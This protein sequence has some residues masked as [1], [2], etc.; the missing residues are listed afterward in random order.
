MIAIAVIFWVLCI[1]GFGVL[2]VFVPTACTF[3]ALVLSVILP[4]VSA[5]LTFIGSRQLIASMTVPDSISKNTP[6]TLKVSVSN[7]SFFSLLRIKI[8][9][10]VENR[11]TGEVIQLMPSVSAG[12]H[13]SRTVELTFQSEHC[14]AMYVGIQDLK[15]TDAF[16]IFRFSAPANVQREA[17]V[18]P[19]LFDINVLYPQASSNSMESEEYS[20]I[21][22]GYD[23]ADVFQIRD[24][25][26]GD[27]PKQIHWKLSGKFDKLIA[28]DP[29][30]P[31]ERAVTVLWERGYSEETP[32]QSDAMEEILI[33]LC[34][35]LLKMEIG[36]RILWNEAETELCADETVTCEDE[37]YDVLPKL[38]SARKSDSSAVERILAIYGPNSFDKVIY[39]GISAEEAL[40]EI[41]PPARVT[42]LSF[43]EPEAEVERIY[44]VNE[45]NYAEALFEIDLN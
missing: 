17:M 24:Y 23:Y 4:V 5:I 29:G 41:C 27:S 44:Q 2:Y 37:L 22:P 19:D 33:S 39:L 13:K 9:V 43:R 31:V 35:A 12:A 32:R 11:L 8:A 6:T 16:G 18:V 10:R 3:A 34:K 42:A 15:V 28:K 7:N 40:N 1:I 38:M 26:E 20:K 45:G 21:K 14:G 25:A 36:C 30:L